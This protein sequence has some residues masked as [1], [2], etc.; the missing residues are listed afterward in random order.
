MASSALPAPASPARP[1]RSAPPPP[2]APAG[3]WA[4]ALRQLRFWLTDYRRTWRGSIYSGV[5]TGSTHP[6][7]ALD[8]AL[9]Y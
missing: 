2:P 8:P 9:A 7:A 1:A 4:F 3:H 6:R 5:L